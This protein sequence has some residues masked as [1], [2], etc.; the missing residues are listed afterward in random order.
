[1]TGGI[2]HTP[3]TEQQRKH[4]DDWFSKAAQPG[5]ALVCACGHGAYRHPLGVPLGWPGR[6]DVRLGMS[7]ATF[8]KRTLAAFEVAESSDELVSTSSASP[9]A[10]STKRTLCGTSDPDQTW[11]RV[12]MRGNCV[13]ARPSATS[14]AASLRRSAKIPTMSVNSRWA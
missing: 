13:A 4:L 5:C 1:M 9:M 3:F 6:D 2:K 14:A 12:G 8:R 10:D 11:P 7:A